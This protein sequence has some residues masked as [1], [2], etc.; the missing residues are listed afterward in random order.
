MGK[1]AYRPVCIKDKN[2]APSK[3]DHSSTKGFPKERAE[4]AKS[5]SLH[6]CYILEVLPIRRMSIFFSIFNWLL[7]GHITQKTP[8]LPINTNML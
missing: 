4:A 8:A 6:H 2:N 7:V 5:D 3:A 1:S